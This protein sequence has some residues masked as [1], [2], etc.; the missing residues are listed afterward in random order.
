LIKGGY[1]DAQFISKVG[2]LSLEEV[3]EIA[4]FE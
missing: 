3:A 2:V 1:R 4:H